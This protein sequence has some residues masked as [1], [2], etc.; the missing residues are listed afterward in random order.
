MHKL[1]FAFSLI[2]IEFPSNGIFRESRLN[3]KIKYQE[4]EYEILILKMEFYAFYC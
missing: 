1:L 2:K 3:L 4:F